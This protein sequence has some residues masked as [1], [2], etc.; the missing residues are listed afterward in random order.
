MD[1][2]LNKYPAECILQAFNFKCLQ[3]TLY[4]DENRMDHYVYYMLTP[5]ILR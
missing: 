3:T 5:Y 4:N 2:I 1:P